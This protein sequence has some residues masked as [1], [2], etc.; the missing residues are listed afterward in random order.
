[1]TPDTDKKIIVVFNLPGR[2]ICEEGFFERIFYHIVPEL[3]M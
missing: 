2:K 3:T 1:M